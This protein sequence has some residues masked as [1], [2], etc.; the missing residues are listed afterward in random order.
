M[1]ELE[2]FAN[3]N[4]NGETIQA[5][6]ANTVIY[7]HLG[8]SALYDHV[9]ITHPSHQ[10]GAYVWANQPPDNPNYEALLERAVAGQAEM[11][12]N[13]QTVSPKDV[14]AFEKA[15]ER[16]IEDFDGVPEDWK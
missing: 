9:F 6:R 8:A 10:F 5:T 1:S 11:H 7:Q 14:Q 15:V 13:I 3:I 4:F 12:L 16:A 2:S